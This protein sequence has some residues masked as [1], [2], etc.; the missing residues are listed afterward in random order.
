MAKNTQKY[1]TH[2][3]LSRKALIYTGIALATVLLLGQLVFN[4]YIYHKLKQQSGNEALT[5][6]LIN[7]AEAHFKATVDARTGKV[8]LNEANIVLPEP[9]TYSNRELRYTYY[10]GAKNTPAELY[11]TAESIL[12]SAE[13]KMWLAVSKSDDPT[14]P[15]KKISNLQACSRGVL[16]R[17]N[18]SPPTS[19]SID[20]TKA[21]QVGLA[22]GRQVY[23]YTED[24]CSGD[25]ESLARYLQKADSY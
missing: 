6:L 11:V 18:S 10:D 3:K 9:V 20:Y 19:I 1:K 4:V 25:L 8:Y 17:F 12:E 21:G 2:K 22:D 13:A 23:L 5:H 15:F 7:A 16:A 14:A 24:K